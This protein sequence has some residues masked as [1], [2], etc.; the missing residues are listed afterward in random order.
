MNRELNREYIVKTIAED[1]LN[2]DVLDEQNFPDVET[3]LELVQNVILS[4]LKDYS[5]LSGTIF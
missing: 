4:H 5:L 1:L 2:H 3:A